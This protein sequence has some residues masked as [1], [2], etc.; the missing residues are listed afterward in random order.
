MDVMEAVME[1]PI[2]SGAEPI[3]S[4]EPAITETGKDDPYSSKAS[5]EYTNW[6]KGLRDSGDPI[7]AKFSRLAKENH[8]QMFALKNEL[9][10][11]TIE[12]VRGLKTALDS[13]IYQDPERGEL[14]GPDAIA[15]LQDQARTYAEIDEKVAAGD[16]SALET[17]DDAMKSG[18]VKMAP[19]IL[20]MAR[21]MDPEGYAKAVLP[22]FV[23]QLRSS[24]LVGNFNAMVDVL[25]ESPPNWLT[26][27]QKSDWINDK[28]SRIFKL[29]TGM[30]GWLNA[31]AAKA[32]EMVKGPQAKSNGADPLADRE[33]ALNDRERDAHWQK[34][35]IPQRD[36]Y[37]NTKFAELFQPYAKRLNLDRDIQESLKNEFGTR[38]IAKAS[39]NPNYV[40]QI[41]RYYAQKT[42]DAATV[43]NFGKVEFDKHAKSVMD[44]LVK[45]RYRPF[46]NGKPRGGQ[47][48]NTNAAGKTPPPSSGV[49]VVSVRPAEGTYDPRGRTENDI[50]NNIFRLKD[51]KVVQYRRN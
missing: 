5:R 21:Q 46:L 19:A 22:H 10:F 18:I 24:D 9:G 25:N 38:I 7:S 8:G 6:L 20:D 4:T 28:M 33:K 16:P 15:A 29:A 30:G 1:E 43:Y 50:Y 26:P 35:V 37:I 3:E 12:D 42:P 23:E 45:E 49:Q 44:A 17:F 2:E 48:G 14:K 40:A 11:K 32:G 47:P 34:N 51:G 13:V 39:Q 31:Q 36:K 27:N 41:N